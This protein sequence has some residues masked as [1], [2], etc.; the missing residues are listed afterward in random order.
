MFYVI[1][2]TSTLAPAATFALHNVPTEPTQAADEN[3]D[4]QNLGMD[5][6]IDTNPEYTTQDSLFDMAETFPHSNSMEF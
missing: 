2:V 1:I 6:D 3:R 5:K 4:S